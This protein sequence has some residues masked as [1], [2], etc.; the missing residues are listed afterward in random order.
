LHQ[1]RPQLVPLLLHLFSLL[2]CLLLL[3]RLGNEAPCVFLDDHKFKDVALLI[4]GPEL[5]ELL[6]LRHQLLSLAREV[7]HREGAVRVVLIIEGQLP[8]KSGDEDS[9]VAEVAVEVLAV[10]QHVLRED[11]L[12]TIHPE[13]GEALLGAVEDLWQEAAVLGILLAL[14][15]H[16][17]SLGELEAIVLLDWRDGERY[18]EAFKAQKIRAAGT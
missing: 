4:D 3:Y 10:G 15:E 16:L 14:V 17:V 13:E 1:L 6:Q 8:R 9:Q 18:E 11:V 7:L 5:I 2:E 12:L